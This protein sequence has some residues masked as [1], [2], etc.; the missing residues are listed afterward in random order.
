MEEPQLQQAKAGILKA[1]SSVRRQRAPSLVRG[2]GTLPGA[3]I[4][5]T[6]CSPASQHQGLTGDSKDVC[7][8]VLPPVAAKAGLVLELDAQ[9]P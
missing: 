1:V 6:S 3:N 8:L 5:T 9:D 2:L 4:N 7:S